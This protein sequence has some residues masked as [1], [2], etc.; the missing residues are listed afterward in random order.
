MNA[1]AAHIL[2]G[3]PLVA[4][5]R[6]G[7]N[8]LLLSNAMHLSDWLDQSV[9]LPMDEALFE[10]L[11][12]ERRANSRHKDTQDLLLDPSVSYRGHKVN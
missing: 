9:T 6:E 12:A 2:R 7:L 11:L 8:G 3:E 5:G 10:K 4:D 1:F